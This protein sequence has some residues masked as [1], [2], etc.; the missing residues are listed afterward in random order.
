MRNQLSRSR[1]S[2]GLAAGVAL[3]GVNALIA[4]DSSSGGGFDGP[5]M[6]DELKLRQLLRRSGFGAGRVELDAYRQLGLAGTINRLVNYDQ[7][8]NSA[9]DARLTNLGFDLSKRAGISRWWLTR[10]LYTARPLEEKMT[11]FWH[12]LLTSGISKV[13]RP[14]PM[15]TQNEFF[16]ANALGNFPDIL[17]GVSKDPAMMLWLDTATNRKGKPNE[18]YARELME[19]FSMGVN[20]YTEQDVQESARAFTGWSLIAHPKLGEFQYRF[21]PGQ[22]DDG[23]KTFLGETGNFDGDNVIDIIVKQPVSARY[24]TGKLFAFF[25]YPNPTADA[26]DPLVQVYQTSQY[27]IKALVQA[28]LTSDAFYSP[29]A[30]RGLIKSPV[31]YVV[32]AARTLGIQTNAQGIPFVL[33]ELG[34]ELFNPPNVAGWPGGPSWLT[35]G[36]WLTRLNLANALAGGLAAGANGQPGR[37]AAATPNLQQLSAGVA[38]PSDFVDALAEL[39]LDGQIQPEQ[40]QVLI[41]YVTPMDPANAD[42]SWLSERRHGALYLTLAMPEYHLA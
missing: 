18:N 15:V 23:S 38:A 31:D 24:L 19:L 42:P 7:V 30:Y 36:T 20:Q 28:I 29:A 34:Q 35:S 37:G 8:D 40:R 25:A 4:I 22:H 14:E 21:A 16:R 11:L 3:A 1:A 33:T 39:L 6:S 41:D 26:L 32:G 9:L 5:P 10:M 13:G 2:S 12:G 17:K 27:S